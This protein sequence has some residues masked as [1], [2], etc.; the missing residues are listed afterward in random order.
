MVSLVKQTQ[1][2]GYKFIFP[3]TKT[4]C[5]VSGSDVDN[6]EMKRK[7]EDSEIKFNCDICHNEDR[8]LPELKRSEVVFLESEEQIVLKFKK[9][10]SIKI[11]CKNHY[12]NEVTNFFSK[13]CFQ[14]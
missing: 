3:Q 13:G 9:D 5:E 11:L 14:K 6:N 7:T 10:R 2:M 8:S 12:R 1:M 4:V